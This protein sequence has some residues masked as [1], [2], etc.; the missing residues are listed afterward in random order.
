MIPVKIDYIPTG[1]KNRSGVKI[2]PTAITIHS[3]AN[4]NAT[5]ADHAKYLKGPDAQARPVSWHYTVDDVQ[6][7]QHLPEDEE[8]Y[9]AGT[10]EGNRSSIGI[11]ICE[12]EDPTRQAKAIERAQH[13]VASIL[14]RRGWGIDRL[15][16]HR[17]W[18]GKN[19]PRILQGPTWRGFM[20]AVGVLLAGPFIDVRGDHWAA[21][22]IAW[23]KA[24]GLMAGYPD[25]TFRPDQP[26]TRAELASVV[27]RIL[28]RIGD[29]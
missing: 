13:L 11:E 3:T 29:G 9:H 22:D 25:G 27:V 4:P 6:V 1:S 18:T 2:P 15:R 7:I 14:K 16:Q 21:G 26:V 20:Q 24:R 10:R 12:F 5:A 28:G 8:G 23:V 19:C 17:D